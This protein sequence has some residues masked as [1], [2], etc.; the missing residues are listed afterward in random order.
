MS[1]DNVPVARPPIRNRFK[2]ALALQGDSVA[3][4]ARDKG[5][6]E[7]LVWMNLSGARRTPEIRAAI[8]VQLQMS[9][10]AIDAEIDADRASDAVA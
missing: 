5:F 3:A 7:S 8:A 4:W 6:I 10:E 9:P 2:A 1:R